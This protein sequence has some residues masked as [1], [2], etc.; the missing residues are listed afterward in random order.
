MNLDTF[1]QYVSDIIYRRGIEYYNDDFIFN[2][3]HEYPDKWTC[4]IEGSDIYEV[5]VELKGNEIISWDCSCPYDDGNICK[6]VVAFLLY[7]KNNRKNC[8][9][10]IEITETSDNSNEILKAMDE[11]DMAKFMNE[12]AEKH[13][14]FKEDLEKHFMSKTSDYKKEV[15]DCFKIRNRDLSY[16]RYGYSNEEEIIAG[17]IS[18]LMDKK[19]VF[20]KKG[21]YEDAAKTALYA[22]KEIG[23][24][25]EEYQ[26][27]DGELGAACQEAADVLNDIINADNVSDKL[28]AYIIEELGE[29][30]KN[31]NYDNY[32][33]ADLDSLLFS[34]T[35]KSSDKTVAIRLLDEALKLEPDSFRTDS[36]VKSKV[37]ILKESGKEDEA[38]EMITKYLYIPR[39]RK[40]RIEELIKAKSYAE[41]ISLIDE[42]IKIAQSK[43]HPGTVSDWKNEKLNIY[44]KLNDTDKIISMSEDLF[45]NGRESMKYYY[46]LKKTIPVEKWTDY[47]HNTLLKNQKEN[48]IFCILPNIYIEEKYWDK[49]MEWVEKNCSLTSFN[50]I[51]EYE[52]HLK[53]HY[54]ERI[55]EFYRS[56]I[57]KYAEQ[58]M[59]RKHYE[60]IAQVLKIMQTYP[61]GKNLVD[62]LI[63]DFRQ[64]YSKRKAMMEELSKF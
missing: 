24:N 64:K 12:Y 44:I 39:I 26:D 62:S 56:N 45:E 40:V 46:I 51:N 7:I 58:N 19:R 63:S 48:G 59:G 25:Y 11:K 15:V 33:L 9:V 16:N 21:I 29:L 49:L 57:V 42:G 60:I 30:I 28:I 34:A 54:P 5:E 1:K 43:Q 20:V 18:D 53:P 55:L 36:L 47:L 27:Y 14:G 10:T 22:M 38:R 13:P 4:E 35:V 61:N 3:N 8:P 41:A 32:N 37:E 31:N 23:D 6:H 2:V 17:N 50:S 52:K